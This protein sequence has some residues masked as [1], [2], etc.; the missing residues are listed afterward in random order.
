LTLARLVEGLRLMG[1]LVSIVRPRQ[2]TGDTAGSGKGATEILVSSLPLPGYRGLRFGLPAGQVLRQNWSAS[3]PDVIYV[4]TEGPLGWSALRV[5][6]HLE[7][8][9]FSGFH[10][11]FD[12][13]SRYYHLGWLQPLVARY[14]Y[15]FHNR[16]Q[17]TLVA[18]SDLRDR[19][20]AIGM[21][22]V[23]ILDR[24]VDSRLFTPARHPRPY[25]AD[26]ARRIMIWS[27]STLG[28]SRP[29]KI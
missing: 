18:S 20:R 22:N 10:T 6:Q 17:G 13:Y 23:S 2:R 8:P 4:A 27:R 29:R 19:L 15:K 24:G 12:H 11:S 7:I 5:A 1:H 9:V 16:T 28:G 26:G 25:A 3:R 21:K 14:L